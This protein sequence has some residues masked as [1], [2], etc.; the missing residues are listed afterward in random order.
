MSQSFEEQVE[1]SIQDGNLP[2]VVL[3][4]TNSKGMEFSSHIRKHILCDC[5][6]AQNLTVPLLKVVLNIPKLLANVRYRKDL[7][8]NLRRQMQYL[9]W[10]L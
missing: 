7:P 9:Q 8:M 3:L 2:G 4:A 10:H 6:R 1:R 5:C